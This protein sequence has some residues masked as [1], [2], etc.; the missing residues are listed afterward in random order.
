MCQTVTDAGVNSVASKAPQLQELAADDCTRLGDG[1]LAALARGCPGLQVLSLRR[2]AKV[3]DAGIIA[4][5][6]RGQLR[7]L[8]V[9]GVPGVGAAS[10]AALAR[11]CGS[12]LEALDVS[13]CRGLPEAA[14][15]LIVDGC[16]GLRELR[17][18]GC[19]QVTDRLVHG[20]SNDGV[21]LQGLAT[22]VH[23]VA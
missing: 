12:R 2:C 5:A 20:H 13:F 8:A 21:T 3:T 18:Y 4:V 11:C 17:V 19:T 10:A 16:P 15:G 22:S 9:G 1:A 14:L 7:R 6:E 23:A